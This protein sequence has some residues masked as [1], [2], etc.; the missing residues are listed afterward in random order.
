MVATGIYHS[1]E[2]LRKENAE[3]DYPI[4][5]DHGGSGIVEKGRPRS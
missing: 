4:T 3:I 1:D 2:A 5:L